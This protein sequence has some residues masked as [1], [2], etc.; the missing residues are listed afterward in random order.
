M[1]NPKDGGR[2]YLIDGEHVPAELVEVDGDPYGV[3]TPQLTPASA[4]TTTEYEE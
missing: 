4:E 2:Y 3:L 1:A